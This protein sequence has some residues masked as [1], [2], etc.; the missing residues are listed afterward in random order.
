M[1]NRLGRDQREDAL[2]SA[3]LFV[4]GVFAATATTDVLSSHYLL[5][6]PAFQEVGFSPF[7]NRTANT[8]VKLGLGGVTSYALARVYER[9]PRVAWVL[10]VVL[11]AVEAIA[12]FRNVRFLE[13][14]K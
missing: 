12:V 11:L 8:A 6:D 7:S 9:R 14:R 3:F 4:L 13:Q 2:M 1:P 5:G 10:T